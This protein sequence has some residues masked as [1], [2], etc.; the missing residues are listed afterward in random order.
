VTLPRGR[1]ALGGCMRDDNYMIFARF[2]GHRVTHP[3]TQEAKRAP[4]RGYQRRWLVE[5]FFA[6]LQW[7]RRL[8]VRWQ[9]CTSSFLSFVQLASTAMLLRQF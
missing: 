2:Q 4:P 8:L 1:T 7:K 5:R 6:W 3:E 9:Y